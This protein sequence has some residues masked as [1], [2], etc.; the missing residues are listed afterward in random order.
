MKTHHRLI[1]LLP[2]FLA[3]CANPSHFV[4]HQSTSIGVDA[5]ANTDTGH[6]HVA[7]G[8][9]R[10]TNTLIPKTK[11]FNDIEEEEQEAMSVVSASETK[12]K[13][14]GLHEVTEQFAT[15]KAARNLAQ[16]PK[17]LGQILTLT[18]PTGP[19]LPKPP[20][21]PMP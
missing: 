20:E 5:A 7:L 19:T 8:Y 17:A 12:I 2:I 4:F 11:T 15:G 13:W 18:V 3:A 1:A 9:D 10:Q 6:V 16:D 14:L 21:G